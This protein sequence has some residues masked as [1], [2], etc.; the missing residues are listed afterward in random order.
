MIGIT[1]EVCFVRPLITKSGPHLINYVSF[2]IGLMTT[3]SHLLLDHET[4]NFLSLL[5]AS[6]IFSYT[7]FL[8]GFHKGL[9][10]YTLYMAYVSKSCDI[11]RFYCYISG[12]HEIDYDFI[13]L[14]YFMNIMILY[15]FNFILSTH[16]SIFHKRYSYLIITI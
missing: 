15:H 13:L 7:V 4:I 10:S 1:F 9:P 14:Y 6:L 2:T 5:Q 16:N 8:K 3:I 12:R 11:P